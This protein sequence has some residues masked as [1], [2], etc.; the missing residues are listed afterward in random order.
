MQCREQCILAMYFDVCPVLSYET[1]DLYPHY[2]TVNSIDILVTVDNIWRIVYYSR[3]S[4]FC[5]YT[6]CMFCVCDFVIMRF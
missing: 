3:C 1:V 4:L 6:Y 2:R 5:E